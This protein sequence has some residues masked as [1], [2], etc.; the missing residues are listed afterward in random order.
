MTIEICNHHIYIPFLIA[1]M[2][3]GIAGIVQEVYVFQEHD[4]NFDCNLN[5]YGK[6]DSWMNC[7]N[8]EIAMAFKIAL[9][10]GCGVV[11]FLERNGRYKW[12]KRVNCNK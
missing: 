7:K 5:D 8:T 9:L 12:F 2:V 3:L 10:V 6:W 1:G 4:Y 11:L